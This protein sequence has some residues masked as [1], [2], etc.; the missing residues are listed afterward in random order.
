MKINNK[1]I[2]KICVKIFRLESQVKRFKQQ[3]E[4][5]EKEKEDLKQAN[6]VLKT[7]LRDRSMQLDEANE[8]NKHLQNRLERLRLSKKGAGGGGAL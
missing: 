1:L 6:R 7:D 5:A 8:T 2:I 4:Q 3:A